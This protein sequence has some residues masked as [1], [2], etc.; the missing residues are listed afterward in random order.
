MS[1][2]ETTT[3]KGFH[4]AVLVDNGVSPGDPPAQILI[5]RSNLPGLTRLMVVTGQG[6]ASDSEMEGQL[7]ILTADE[8]RALVT[9][10]T[11]ELLATNVALLSR[12]EPTA[13]KKAGAGGGALRS[14]RGPRRER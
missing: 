5:G 9:A 13:A 14:T 10:L 2:I 1:L 6:Q 7:L 12:R 3:K 4:V 8:L 11:A